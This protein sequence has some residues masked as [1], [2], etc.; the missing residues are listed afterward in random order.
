MWVV[1]KP[2]GACGLGEHVPCCARLLNGAGTMLL[3]PELSPAEGCALGGGS[4]GAQAGYL[5]ST[6][7]R[8]PLWAVPGGV[9]SCLTGPFMSTCAGPAIPAN[10]HLHAGDAYSKS[11]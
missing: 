2:K 4:A 9:C 3:S 5:P 1:S 7:L 10:G 8:R 11:D 6:G